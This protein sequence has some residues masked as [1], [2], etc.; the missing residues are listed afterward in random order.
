MR[1]RELLDAIE[2]Y[3]TAMVDDS[4]SISEYANREKI[5]TDMLSEQ[6]VESKYDIKKMFTDLRD[7]WDTLEVG[8]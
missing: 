8:K 5:L 7:Y 3:I 4:V 2:N 6:P 1:N